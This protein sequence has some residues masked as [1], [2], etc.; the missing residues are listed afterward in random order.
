MPK[1]KYRGV[2]SGDVQTTF[3]NMM[4]ILEQSKYA[5]GVD[6]VSISMIC[7]HMRLSIRITAYCV[8]HPPSTVHKSTV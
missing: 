2:D 7:I 4:G 8:R 5:S 1:P 6:A 3:Q